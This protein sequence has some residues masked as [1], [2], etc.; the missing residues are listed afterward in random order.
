MLVDKETVLFSIKLLYIMCV[1]IPLNFCFFSSFPNFL[2]SSLPSCPINLPPSLSLSL[3]TI[4]N[5]DLIVCL[6]NG[7]IK[8]TGTHDELMKLEGL[9]YDMVTSQVRI[10]I[11]I[12]NFSI[13]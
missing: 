9:Y 8:E 11:N 3:S 7:E 6:D 13:A 4:R 10:Y 1:C 5:A 2:I 12:L